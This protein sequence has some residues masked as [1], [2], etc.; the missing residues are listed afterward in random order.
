MSRILFIVLFAV[1]SLYVSDNIFAQTSAPAQK[2]QDLVA[3][4]GKTKYKKKEKGNFVVEVYIDI[5][6]EAVI[7]NNAAEYAGSYVSGDGNYRLDL[8]ISGGRIEGS[9]TDMYFENSNFDKQRIRKFTLRDARI[10]GALLTATKVYENGQTLKFEGVFVDRT[11]TNGKNPNEIES[12]ETKFGI[13]FIETN[14]SM[15]NRVFC[16]FK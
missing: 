7:K 14:D 16:E 9:G 11:V 10:E 12:R 8:S 2:T 15:T 5:K 1:L 6:N 13:G 3:A 4:L